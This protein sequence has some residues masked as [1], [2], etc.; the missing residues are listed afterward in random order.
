M[1]KDCFDEDEMQKNLYNEWLKRQTVIDSYEREPFPKLKDVQG[2]IKILK[3]LYDKTD[4]ADGEDSEI[5][6]TVLAVQT[7]H[8]AQGLY[9]ELAEW[10]ENHI[11]GLTFLY[12]ESE[13]HEGIDGKITN[14][15][16]HEEQGHKYK[17]SKAPEL[18]L[19]KWRSYFAHMMMVKHE[20]NDDHGW[21]EIAN[22]LLALNEGEIQN[23][24]KPIK[25]GASKNKYTLDFLRWQAVLHVYSFRGIGLKKDPALI[26]VADKLCCSIDAILKWEKDLGKKYDADRMERNTIKATAGYF[27]SVDAE[28]IEEIVQE[29]KVEK[30]QER[31]RGEEQDEFVNDMFSKK[32]KEYLVLHKNFS[33]DLIREK[34]DVTKSN[35]DKVKIVWE[36]YYKKEVKISD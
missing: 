12:D 7:I 1:G 30:E 11:F 36:N 20:L 18:S 33:L 3:Y 9:Y 35:P 24:V 31:M 26:K 19:E 27:D 22:A 2:T 6:K 23:A 28:V 4:P 14:S 21:L 17:T 16:R 13:E 34:I 15:H 32:Y 5:M 25:K 29:Y 8:M 10:A